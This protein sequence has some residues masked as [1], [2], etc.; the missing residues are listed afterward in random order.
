MDAPNSNRRFLT[1]EDIYGEED[2]VDQPDTA[3]FTAF[4][5]ILESILAPIFTDVY[6]ELG[7]IELTNVDA[8]DDHVLEFVLTGYDN[9]TIQRHLH[10]NLGNLIT[11]FAE[12]QQQ[13]L[14]GVRWA[15]YPTIRESLLKQYDLSE[16]Q[17]LV[18]TVNVEVVPTLM[19][20]CSR[21]HRTP[22][23]YGI[24]HFAI[25]VIFSLTIEDISS[26]EPGGSE[27][28]RLRLENLCTPN[29]RY[30]LQELRDWAERLGASY[31]EDMTR[32]E[33]CRYV[34][35]NAM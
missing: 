25:N 3:F 29:S 28:A 7:G 11:E 27:A 14:N 12:K 19:P 16:E 17:F 34:R 24:M 33:L 18:R 32:E 10:L 4:S 6:P 31:T 30:P 5:G 23:T 22:D 35:S 8:R 15:I 1:I 9:K 21:Y 20:M 2:E 13:I 26:M